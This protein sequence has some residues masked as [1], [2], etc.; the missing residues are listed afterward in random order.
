MQPHCSVSR[1]PS[2]APPPRA[3]LRNPA[4][5]WRNDGMALR[6]VVGRRIRE[7]REAAG[8]TQEELAL[9]SGHSKSTISRIEAG[10]T[11]PSDTMLESIVNELPRDTVP[12]LVAAEADASYTLAGPVIVSDKEKALLEAFRE[13]PAPFQV[14]LLLKAGQIEHYVANMTHLLRNQLRGPTSQTFAAWERDLNGDLER[15][16]L[17]DPST[18]TFPSKRTREGGGDND[19]DN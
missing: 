14:Y 7:A 12:P 4:F 3:G 9:R 5:A 16:N 6:D 2:Q 11:W 13:L 19:Q 10:K 15:Q 18:F 1:N 17:Y 8:I